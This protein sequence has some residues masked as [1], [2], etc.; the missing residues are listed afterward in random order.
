MRPSAAAFL[1]LTL[2]A[3]TEV[4]AAGPG[5]RRLDV[6]ARRAEQVACD[7][8]RTL[9]H[10]NDRPRSTEFTTGLR[11]L[12]IAVGVF[13]GDDWSSCVCRGHRDRIARY[14][15]WL[16]EAFADA[17]GEEFAEAFACYDDALGRAVMSS[18]V[19]RVTTNDV[20]TDEGRDL[21]D[22]GVLDAAGTGSLTGA[23][24][25]AAV[26]VRPSGTMAGWARQARA[27]TTRAVSP[28]RWATS[29]HATSSSKWSRH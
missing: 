11:R 26:A 20:T 27:A 15:W 7:A 12:S 22:G 17:N 1:P 3:I 10:G 5:T 24:R 4:Q 13:I 8:W 29:R 19:S 21:A 25:V 28:L 9:L 14:Q 6:A 16:E 18:A 23:G 2:G